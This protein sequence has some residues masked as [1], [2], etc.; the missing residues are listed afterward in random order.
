MKMEKIVL[1]NFDYHDIVH[2]EDQ[3]IVE[4]LDSMPGFKSFM[5]NTI[6]AL[7]EKYIAIE[8][9]G[10]GIH[11]NETCLFDLDNQLKDVCH[12]LGVEKSTDL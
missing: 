7:R 8:Y 9:G 3:A 10:N 4:K 5:M 1:S 12:T 2:P 11:A 6:C